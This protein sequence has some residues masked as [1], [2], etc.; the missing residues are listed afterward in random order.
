MSARVTSLRSIARPV[1]VVALSITVLVGVMFATRNAR[2]KPE[3]M[4]NDANEIADALVEA[5]RNGADPGVG[6]APTATA[7]GVPAV[8][9]ATEQLDRALQMKGHDAGY[10]GC[11]RREI[12]RRL[13][14]PRLDAAIDITVSGSELMN[15]TETVWQ[16]NHL[17][18]RSSVIVSRALASIDGLCANSHE[19]RV[20]R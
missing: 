2:S 20:A 9:Q 18:A 14:G 7:T 17:D 16:R 10:T 6:A 1:F 3:G 11:F 19:L 8:D 13:D 15:G 4:R 5:G 12:A